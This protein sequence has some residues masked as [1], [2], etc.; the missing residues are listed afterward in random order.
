MN[1]IGYPIPINNL[2]IFGDK[3]YRIIKKQCNLKISDNLKSFRINIL[4]LSL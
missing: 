1:V 4:W 2:G 3:S